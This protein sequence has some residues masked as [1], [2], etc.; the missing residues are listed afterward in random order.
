MLIEEFDELSKLNEAIDKT[1]E[2]L[3]NTD[4]TDDAC[5]KLAD[6]YTK[7]NKNKQI[8]AELLLK[9]E[10]ATEKK[11]QFDSKYDLDGRTLDQKKSETKMRHQEVVEDQ[12]IRMREIE[13]KERE[14]EKPD[15]VSKDALVAAA[16]SIAGILVIVGYERVNVI[17]SKALGFVLK[18]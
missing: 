5:S 2:V 14:A 16:A 9:A 12:M 15:R 17:A 10:E 18:R 11:S 7:L 4:P 3:N 13:L 1:L 8:I 6:Q